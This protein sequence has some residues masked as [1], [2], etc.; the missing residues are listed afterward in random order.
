MKKSCSCKKIDEK[1]KEM[2]N[3]TRTISSGNEGTAAALDTESSTIP[4]SIPS[5]AMGGGKKTNRTR[6]ARRSAP[7][8]PDATTTHVELMPHQVDHVQ[9]LSGTLDRFRFALDLSALGAGKTYCATKLCESRAIPNVVVIA[10]LTVLPKWQHMQTQHGLPLVDAI[11]YCSLRSIKCKQP[12]HGFLNRE[13]RVTEHEVDGELQQNER[14]FF[15]STEKWR[16]LVD[17][18]VL[19]I[20][21]EIQNVKNVSSQFL[22]VKEMM[23][24]ILD[25]TDGDNTSRVLLLSGTPVDKTEQVVNLY[26]A[27]GLIKT[28]SLGHFNPQTRKCEAKGFRQVIR[29]H[30]ELFPGVFTAQMSGTLDH[31]LIVASAYEAHSYD[32]EKFSRRDFFSD[33]IYRLFRDIF[34]AKIAARMPPVASTNAV[35]KFNA[36]Y[37]VKNDDSMRLLATAVARLCSSVGYD[38]ST[39]TVALQNLT[40]TDRARTFQQIARAMQM[41]ETAKIPIFIRVA[42]EALERN[43]NQKVAILLNYSDSIVDIAKALNDFSP[44]VVRG[45]TSIRNRA[46]ALERFQRAD[47]KYRLLI[48]NLSCVST[49][50]DLDDKD[51]RFPRLGLVSPNYSTITLHQLTY[52]FLRA[53]TRSDAHVHFVFGRESINGKPVRGLTELNVLNCLARKSKVMK[54]VAN[55]AAADETQMLYPGEFPNWSET[56][57]DCQIQTKT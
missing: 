2:E 26:K 7:V 37:R 48:G 43:P 6:K 1:K 14:T 24:D 33:S 45:S 30:E 16:K 47:D 28:H 50:V 49:G 34:I 46:V 22:S 15:H 41:I 8:R 31:A 51:G 10:P 13:D 57:T 56:E 23:R 32:I 21:D 12:K 40:A 38:D 54:E 29:F 17:E 19:L 20:V 3:D 18:G 42:R 5:V 52:R 25:H 39:N 9:R 35:H 36:F 44:L 4:I 11:S 55:S 53:D 27:L